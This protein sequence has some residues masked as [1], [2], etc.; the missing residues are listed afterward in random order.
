MDINL[1]FLRYA[2]QISQFDAHTV[3]AKGPNEQRTISREDLGYYHAVVIGAVYEFT[4][5]LVLDSPSAL[6]KPLAHCIREHPFLGVLVAD[7]HTNKAYYQRAPVVNLEEHIEILSEHISADTKGWHAVEEVLKSNLDRPFSH[8]IPPWRVIV[9][10]LGGPQYFIAGEDAGDSR[11]IG[12]ANR[13]TIDA[14]VAAA[15]RHASTTFNIVVFSLGPLIAVLVP[16]FVANWLGV[17]AQI[18]AVDDETWAGSPACFDPGHP[19]ASRSKVIVRVVEGCLVEKAVQESRKHGAKLTG[20]LHQFIVRALSKTFAGSQTTK[21]ISETSIN[22]RKSVG[23]PLNEMGEFASAT[24]VTHPKS[25]CSGPLTQDE[26]AI[27]TSSTKRFAEVAVTLHDQP[28]GLLRYVPNMKKWLSG[29]MGQRRDCSY[30][31]SNIGVFV[32]EHPEDSGK[33]KIEHVVFAQ[34][35]HVSSAPI[36][37][38]FS[39]IQGGSMVYTVTWP[40]GALGVAETEEENLIDAVCRSIQIDFEELL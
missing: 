2:S 38:N 20:T 39:T 4:D 31:I 3:I 5:G 23:V 29:K 40:T 27:A 21:F 16:S 34:P 24:Y 1:E 6:F 12:G 22:M 14:A 7:R 37:F 18:S 13:R 36:C 15:F 17:E 30:E 8:A 25:S 10:P 35:G 32:D 19:E 9:L 11:A 33:A 26:W 28:I